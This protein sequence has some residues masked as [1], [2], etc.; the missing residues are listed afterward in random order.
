MIPVYINSYY[1]LF[2][3]SL[4]ISLGFGL[5][6]KLAKIIILRLLGILNEFFCLFSKKFATNNSISVKLVIYVRFGP[7]FIFQAMS[8]NVLFNLFCEF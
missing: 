6:A 4:P 2:F 5:I 7:F 1:T 8:R 3:I